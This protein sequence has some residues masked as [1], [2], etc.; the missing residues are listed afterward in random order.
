MILLEA[1][2]PK[3]Q[4][5]SGILITEDWKSLPPTG[6]ILSVGPDVNGL[7]ADDMVLFNRY[8]SIIVEGDKRL[9]QQSHI[10]GV[11]NV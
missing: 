1:E 8:G 11:I 9:C 7:K 4:T 2:K 6:K 3:S 10:L 5:E